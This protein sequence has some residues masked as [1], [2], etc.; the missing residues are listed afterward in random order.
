M[1]ATTTAGRAAGQ[2]Q[3]VLFGKLWWVGLL[4][5]GA[6][7]LANLAAAALFQAVLRPDPAFLPLSYGPVAFFTVIGGLGAVAVYAIVGRFS[8]QPLSLY[9]RIALIVMVVSCIPDVLMPFQPAAFPGINWPNAIA[10]IVFH[11]IGWA[12]IVPLLTRLAG[13]E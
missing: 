7:V 8:R 10:L 2:S 11:V 6:A 12:V 4:A 5:I 3:R 13:E 9:R 1:T